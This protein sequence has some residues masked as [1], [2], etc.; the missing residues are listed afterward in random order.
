MDNKPQ[1][2]VGNYSLKDSTAELAVREDATVTLD[3]NVEKLSPQ[4]FLGKKKDEIQRYVLGL[5]HV[6]SVD[7][8]FSPSWLM[9][10]P[11]VPD[12][13]KIVVKNVQ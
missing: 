13:I 3:A 10:A 9:S 6:A 1:I 8:K 2:T 4:Y 11:T 7:V 5:D 12:R